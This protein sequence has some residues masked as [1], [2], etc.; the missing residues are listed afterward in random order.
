MIREKKKLLN[1]LC[2]KLN[3]SDAVIYRQTLK[4]W[5]HERT[6]NNLFPGIIHV[7]HA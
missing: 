7:A 6:L 3:Y 2:T 4:L 5:E 1:I